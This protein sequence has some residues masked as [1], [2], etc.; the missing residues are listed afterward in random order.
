M[1][2]KQNNALLH[3][4]LVKADTKRKLKLFYNRIKIKTQHFKIYREVD[5]LGANGGQ[6]MI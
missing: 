4:N 3:K 2:D 6:K 5:G 1:K